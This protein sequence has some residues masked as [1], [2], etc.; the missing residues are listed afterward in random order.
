MLHS[1]SCRTHSTYVSWAFSR[2]RLPSFYCHF[3]SQ[4]RK[5]ANQPSLKRKAVYTTSESEDDVPLATPVKPRKSAA[6][7]TAGALAANGS[8]RK[9][10]GRSK[11]ESD[12]SDS[13]FSNKPVKS[14]SKPKK[15]AKK[16][17]KIEDDEDDAL[18][19]DIPLATPKKVTPKPV[20]GKSKAKAK[21]KVKPESDGDVEMEADKSSKKQSK[22]KSDGDVEMDED[23][24]P[25]KQSKGKGKAIP[26]KSKDEDDGG[27]AT[28]KKKKEEEEEEVFRWWD[29]PADVE[30]DGSVKWKTL[31]HNGVLFPP[32]YQP[33]P[34]D[35]KMNYEGKPVDLPVESEEVAGFYGA[36]LNT[37]HAENATFKSNFF[38]DFK[39]VLKDFP[40][41]DG[42]KITR[43]E[44]CDFTPMFNYYEAEKAK[45]KAMTS[46]EKKVAKAEK[47][48]FEEPFKTCLLDGRKEKIGN[49]RI[50]PPGLFRGRGDH[51]RKG[52]LKLRVTPEDITIN[53]GKGVPIPKPNM[54]GKWRNI[55][56]DDT[57]TW[58]AN[59]KENVNGQFKYVFLA[60][61]SSLKG[62]S[63]MQK[64][65]KARELKNHVDAI[66]A[67]Y[68]ADLKSKLS[69]DRQRA[70]AMYF[71]DKLALRAGNE[72]GED[73]A[74]TVGCCSLRCEHVTLQ[75]PN[76]L[77][78]DFLGKDSI[79]YY[80]TVEVE[81]QIFKNVR[82]FKGDGKTDE[83]SLFDRV[84]TGGLNKHLASYMKGL[85]AKVFRTYNASITF[86]DQLDNNTP[87]TTNQQELLNAYNKANRMVAILCNHQRAVPKGH[88]GSMEKMNDKLRT[89]KY[90]R[91]KLRHEMFSLDK[92]L[93]KKS[94][95]AKEESDLDD[96]WIEKYEEECQKKEVEK[97]EKKFAKDNEKLEAEGKKVHGA[98]VLEER[99]EDIKAEY[100][101]LEQEREQDEITPKK[102]RTVEK[103][104]DMIHKLDERIKTFR[105]QMVD[106][107]E[108]K[109]VSLGTSKINYLDPRI[110]AAWCK[111][112]NVPIEK[113]FSKTL[114]V[115]FPWAMEVE[116]DWKF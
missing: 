26:K 82:I 111:T 99:I 17:L 6:A 52:S 67:D 106:R 53:I 51:P 71:I 3:Q 91:R 54:P 85:T 89:L 44:D 113:I 12:V 86:Q 30:G 46:A 66:R 43:F 2:F 73:E 95:W 68:N 45:R 57:V 21:V 101:R 104:Q 90:Q 9:A 20:N 74:D 96:E 80:N 62:Q 98:K 75:P 10:N 63:D 49:F 18:S 13:S 56:H 34:K 33:L 59:W 69:A 23:K 32:P 58:L 115:K 102:G 25:K 81:D 64:F 29:A 1:F 4:A 93:K 41:K 70:T 112:H 8:G 76:K 94:A 105:L 60:A 11:E 55:I 47:D 114:L 24:S 100:K 87:N 40:S 31:E 50:E 16:K 19:D 15:P 110:T 78:F 97:A 61:G 109:E 108:G 92:K 88:A 107:E 37:D 65:E 27:K 7:P 22:G 14:K 36:M 42:T 116:E 48:A 5:V 38:Q 84:T 79:R 28:K 35:V 72:K 83:D 103:L 39:L 77:V